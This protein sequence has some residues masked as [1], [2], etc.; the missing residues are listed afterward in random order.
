MGLFIDFEKG[1]TLIA[2]DAEHSIEVDGCYGPA[3]YQRP[4]G[5]TITM[6]QIVSLIRLSRDCRQTFTLQVRRISHF[7]DSFIQMNFEKNTV[8][9]DL[10]AV[11]DSRPEIF[12][13]ERPEQRLQVLLQLHRDAGIRSVHLP[14]FF[15]KWRMNQFG[16]NFSIRLLNYL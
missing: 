12:L 13:V 1:A 15:K 3:C 5:Y 2:H 9:F 10:R 8:R 11:L 4:V 14:D 6:R 16:C 7:A